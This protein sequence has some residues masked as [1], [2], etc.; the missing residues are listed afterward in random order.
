MFHLLHSM[1][2]EQTQMRANNSQIT[3]ARKYRAARLKP[4]QIN[5]V[6]WR[7]VDAV[8]NEYRISVPT[9]AH[10]AARMIDDPV[11]RLP[12]DY[13]RRQGRRPPAK[14]PVSLLQY[15]HIG[16]HAAQHT[17]NPHWV[18]LTIKTNG[19]AN[20]VAGYAHGCHKIGA[21]SRA[22]GAP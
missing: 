13:F 21:Q 19:L 3:T 22:S 14:T 18:P 12:S 1:S 16:I 20:I 6:Q 2:A 8:P 17:R 9:E 11:I 4:W 5:A 7:T 15:N 10:I